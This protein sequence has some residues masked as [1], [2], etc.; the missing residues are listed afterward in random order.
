MSGNR[1][2]SGFICERSQRCELFTSLLQSKNVLNKC[3]IDRAHWMILFQN[4]AMKT[5]G[6]INEI[7]IIVF[8]LFI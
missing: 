4:I 7:L 1:F 6:Y 2:S 8:I 5:E 3:F